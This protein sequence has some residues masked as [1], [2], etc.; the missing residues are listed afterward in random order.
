MQ[1]PLPDD[2]ESAD[3]RRYGSIKW[4]DGAKHVYL[5]AQNIK[6]DQEFLGTTLILVDLDATV[7]D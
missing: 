1:N 5:V 3:A 2:Q 7:M 4:G 6:N